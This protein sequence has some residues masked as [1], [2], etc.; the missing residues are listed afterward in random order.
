MELQGISVTI[1]NA[2][3]KNFNIY[4]PP[5]SASARYTPD[6]SRI[7]DTDDDTLFLGDINA[8]NVAWQSS[9]DDNRGEHLADQIASSNFCILNDNSQTR[10]PANGNLSSPDISLILAHLALSVVWETC[11]ALNSNHLPISIPFLD[12]QP[13]PRM[14]R[15]YTNF[16]RAKWGLFTSETECLFENTSLLTRCSAGEKKFC[17]ILLVAGYLRGIVMIS[18][19]ACLEKPSTS[20]SKET[21]VKSLT[22]MIQ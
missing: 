20:P 3:L 8:H 22:P 6:I 19:L 14:A 17:E 9:L 12:D 13:P 5:V 1:N 16:K 10:H 15:S 21:G 4:I 2:L 7:L 11:V 18:Y